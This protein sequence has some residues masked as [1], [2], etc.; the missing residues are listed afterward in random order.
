MFKVALM[1]AFGLV[2]KVAASSYVVADLYSDATSCASNGAVQASAITQ[3]G[4]CANVPTGIELPPP[5]NI[6][7]SFQIGSCANGAEFVSVEVDVFT[8]AG[9]GGKAI[10]YTFSDQIP[11]ACEGD[12]K[13]SCQTD[14][15]ALTQ[16]WPNSAFYYDDA[17]CATP[18]GIVAVLPVCAAVSSAQGSAS[19]VVNCDAVTSMHMVGYNASTTCSGVVAFDQW[20]PTQTCT[21]LAEVP[22]PVPN[23]RIPGAGKLSL[24]DVVVSAYYK[25]SCTGGY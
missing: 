22:V 19:A 16:A 5:L 6:A 4:V 18:A 24:A 12:V 17:T 3:V 20:I 15:V 25:A 21:L 11:I 10:P 14:P 9:C 13:L 23:M 1:I 2:A 7:K 8:D